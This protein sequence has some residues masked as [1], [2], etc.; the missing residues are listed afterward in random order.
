MEIAVTK[1]YGVIVYNP[2][3]ISTSIRALKLDFRLTHCQS[4]ESLLTHASFQENDLLLIDCIPEVGSHFVFLDRIKSESRPELES[5]SVVL[6][7]DDLDLEQRLMACELGADDCISTNVSH[8][9]LVT[10]LQSTIYNAIA[11]KQLKEQ[12][13]AASDVAMAAMTNTSD[14]GANIQFLLESYQCENLDQLGQLLFQSLN[15]YGLTCSLQMRGEHVTKNM[16]ANGMERTMESRLLNELKNAG[17][18]Y[19]FGCRTVANYGSTSIL[20]K[21]MPVDDSIRYGVIKDN[22][23]ALLQGTDAKVKALDTQTNLQL[24]HQAQESLTLQ[25]K[26]GVN[27]LDAQYR[28]LTEKIAGVVNQMAGAVESAMQT[29]LLTDEQEVIL[30]GKLDDGKNSVCDLFEEYASMDDDLKAM[31]ENTAPILLSKEDGATVD[32]LSE[33]DISKA[34]ELLKQ[35]G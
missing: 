10:R 5:M 21:N 33:D 28:M 2:S 27:D 31:V 30:L 14:L 25:L 12:L 20:I 7:A 11:N 15:Y 6:L 8:D 3:S 22:I 35:T 13:K 4:F 32:Q 34:I 1:K 16:E 23:F 17:R 19:D 26:Q 24:E 18:F 29:M 9:D